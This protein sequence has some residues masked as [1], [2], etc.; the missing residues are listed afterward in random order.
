MK[1]LLSENIQDQFIRYNHITTYNLDI[2]FNKS[3]GQ[4]KSLKFKNKFRSHPKSDIISDTI[5]IPLFYSLFPH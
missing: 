4:S 1:I 2:Q 5:Y 3:F